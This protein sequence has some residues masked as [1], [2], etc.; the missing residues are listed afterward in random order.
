MSPP[1]SRQRRPHPGTPG[2][3]PSLAHPAAMAQLAAHALGKGE[4]LGSTPSGG[5]AVRRQAQARRS[6]PTWMEFGWLN[7]A[8]PWQRSRVRV[9]SSARRRLAGACT[10]GRRPERDPGPG[11]RATRTEFG[12]LNACLP[13]RLSR[14]R[15]PSS[16]LSKSRPRPAHASVWRNWQTRWPQV[17][18]PFGAWGFNSLHGH[19]HSAGR[20]GALRLPRRTRQG[21]VLDQGRKT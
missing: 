19:T 2:E 7:A 6:G 4:V 5:S 16:A 14:V 13:S 18:V 12:W 10:T 9:P 21:S 17:P 15:V 11:T 8:L 3:P 1:G 20:A